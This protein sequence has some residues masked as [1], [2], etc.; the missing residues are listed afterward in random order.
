MAIKQVEFSGVTR[1]VALNLYCAHL[2]QRSFPLSEDAFFAKLDAVAY[3][4]N[5]FDCADFVRAFFA[6]KI[7]PRNGLPSRRVARLLLTNA[8]RCS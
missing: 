1:I 8:P 4:V 5:A 6:Q 2:G 3:L 7:A